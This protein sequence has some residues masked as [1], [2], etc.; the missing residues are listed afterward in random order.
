MCPECRR[1]N[2]DRACPRQA[3]PMPQARAMFERGWVDHKKGLPQAE[4]NMSYLLG[5]EA[6]EDHTLTELAESLRKAG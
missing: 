3:N 5:W 6:A 2:C 1:P 4:A